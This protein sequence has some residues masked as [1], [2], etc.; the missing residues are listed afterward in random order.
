MQ[1]VYDGQFYKAVKISGPKHN[2]LSISLGK[3]EQTTITALKQGLDYRQL[4]DEDDVLSQVTS[5]IEQL[6]AE[7]GT[8]YFVEKIQFV[9]SDTPSQTVYNEL[10]KAI[11]TR[12]HEGKEFIKT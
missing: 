5:G 8:D 2:L 12:V 1:F 4:V 11:V 10:V 7:L 9:P 6:N 3:S